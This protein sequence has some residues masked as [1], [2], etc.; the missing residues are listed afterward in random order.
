LKARNIK[1]QEIVAIKKFKE[2]TE[3]QDEL[4]RKTMLREVKILRMIR[5]EN[6][7][8][9]KEAFR[10]KGILFFFSHFLHFLN[11]NEHSHF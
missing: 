3:E 8:Y 4:V 5:H 2:S 1:T 9:L 10:R 7:V 11:K 6:I